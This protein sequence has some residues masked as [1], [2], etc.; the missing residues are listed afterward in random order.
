[1]VRRSTDERS[2]APN[3]PTLVEDR[4]RSDQRR[5]Q[6]R[7]KEVSK[8]ARRRNRAL[9]AIGLANHSYS[10]DIVTILLLSTFDRFR[11]SDDGFALLLLKICGPYE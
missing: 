7:E 6:G 11:T 1:M 10:V 4:K 2:N 5:S 8:W 3:S 9:K